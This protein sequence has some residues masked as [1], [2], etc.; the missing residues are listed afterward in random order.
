MYTLFWSGI[1]YL[2]FGCILYKHRN[3]LMNVIDGAEETSISKNIT[4]LKDKYLNII[5]GIHRLY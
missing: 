4:S 5:K 2:V 3:F 1:V